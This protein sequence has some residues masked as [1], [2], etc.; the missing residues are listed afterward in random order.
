MTETMGQLRRTH[1]SIET[2]E[3]PLGNVV[4]VA[5]FIAKSRDIGNLIFADLRDIKGIIQLAFDDSTDREIFEKA[6]SLRSEAVVM[7]GGV[8]RERSS[9]NP[10]L[11]TGNIELFVTEL[12]IL[13]FAKTTPFEIR[14]EINVRDDLALKYRYLDLR[15]PELSKNMLMRH[16]IV[17]CARDYYDSENFIEIETPILI[18]STPEGARDYLVPSRVQNGKFYAL[19]QS[20]QLYKQLLMLSGFD[21]YMQ[22]AKCFRDEDLRADRQ[23]EFTQIDVEMSFCDVDDIIAVN[24]GFLVKIFHEILD[25]KIKAPFKRITYKQAMERFGSDK[26][27]TRFGLELKDLSAIVENSEFAVF[28]NTL[29]AGGTVRGINAKG[30][31]DKLTRKEIDSLTEHVK[32]YRAKGLAF[33]K[34]SGGTASGSYE[35]FLSEQEISGIR[36]ALDAQDGDVLFIVADKESIVFDALGALRLEV[37]KR[38]GLIEKDTFDLL[39]VTDFPLFEYDDEEDR[40]YAKH[41]PFTAPADSDV[42]KLETDRLNCTAKAYDIILNGNEIG[43]GSIRI[44]NPDI[45][46]TMFSALGFTDEQAEA[47]FGFL[48]EAYTYGA[49]PHGGIAFGLDR[50][51]MLLLGKESIRDVI[52]FPKVQNGGELMTGCPDIVSEKQLEELAIKLT[53]EQN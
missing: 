46:R 51:V 17:K 37:A 24:E 18:R 28:K 31:A 34:L 22:I 3:S 9:K 41:H 33:A 44:N 20:P 1:Y 16:K 52:A 25:V 29:A 47:Q 12:K 15:R 21:R 49:P 2:L 13:S 6:K 38:Y 19:P 4:T 7:A 5:G 14:D 10:N 30:L 48:M 11:P 36:T 43:G 32:T 39:W 40:F 8:I 42:E 53:P 23:P 35:K 26:P 45:Q 50:L 27:D